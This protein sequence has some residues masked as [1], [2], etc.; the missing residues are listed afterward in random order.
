MGAAIRYPVG[1]T[2]LSGYLLL[3]TAD[4]AFFGPDPGDAERTLWL[5][6]DEIAPCPARLLR[7]RGAEARLKLAFTGQAG[8]AL[9]AWLRRHFRP[10][11]GRGPRGVLEIRPEGPDQFR[12]VPETLSEAEVE[13]FLPAGRV[14]LQGARPRVVLHP[15]MLD[16]D[17]RLGALVLPEP[18][19]V[20]AVRASLAGGLEQAGWIPNPS[21]GGGL[22]LDGG[23]RRNNAQLHPV[24]LAEEL[25]P[26]LLSLAVGF[27]LGTLDLGVL[28]VADGRLGE[29]LERPAGRAPASLKRAE[30]ELE[31]LGFLQRGPIYV[32]GLSCRR[33]LR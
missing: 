21:V 2:V 8:A 20:G 32:L 22:L 9:R 18:P 14:Y 24:L 12:L 23:L 31:A 30:R 16:L 11:K 10:R 3:R 17:A 28:V 29:R 25:Y 15:A 13:V 5:L 19:S 33:E 26:A 4:E 6:T 7:A 27:E 1:Q